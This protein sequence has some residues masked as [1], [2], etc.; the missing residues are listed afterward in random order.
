MQVGFTNKIDNKLYTN[1][2]MES[3]RKAKG[4]LQNVLYIYSIY[5]YFLVIV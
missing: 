5:V 1:K 3:Q 4:K 2:N